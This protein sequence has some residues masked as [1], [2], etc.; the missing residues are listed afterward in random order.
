MIGAPLLDVTI[1][2]GQ[3]KTLGFLLRRGADPNRRDS[4]GD[5]PLIWDIKKSQ[6]RTDQIQVHIIETLIAAGADSNLRSGLDPGWTPIIW[7]SML[8]ET[9]IVTSLLRGGAD[10]NAT[11]REGQRAL[12]YARNADVARFLIAA[13]ADPKLRGSGE[14]PEETAVRLGHF[15]VLAVLTNEMRC[16]RGRTVA[17]SIPHPTIVETVTFNSP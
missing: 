5:T 11:D 6:A 7:A 3:E 14:T 1:E 16:E 8:G 15:D 13:G 2:Y 12:N 17:L 10:I 9:K 4:L